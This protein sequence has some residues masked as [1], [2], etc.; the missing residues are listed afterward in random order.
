[1]DPVHQEDEFVQLIE[2]LQ[3]I[4][5]ITVQFRVA[6]QQFPEYICNRNE[7]PVPDAEHNPKDTLQLL[8]TGHVNEHG[9]RH[10]M[11]QFRD[12]EA[13]LRKLKWSLWP[14]DIQ[15]LG[16]GA[17][18]SV[19]LIFK[20]EDLYLPFPKRRMAALKTQQLSIF[21]AEKMWKEMIVMKCV[22]HRNIVDY[23][24]AFAVTPKT[25]KVYQDEKKQGLHEDSSEDEGPVA[26]GLTLGPVTDEASLT[27]LQRKKYGRRWRDKAAGKSDPPQKE[28]ILVDLTK[29]M[30][31]IL[32][33]YA[34]AGTLKT[35]I[36][37]Y[38]EGYL[39]EGA[40]LFYMLEIIAGLSYMH[41]KD[42]VH[43]DLHLGNILLKYNSDGRTKRCLVC[44][45]GTSALRASEQG[46]YP[47]TMDDI[48]RL[49]KVIMSQMVRGLIDKQ[50]LP[51]PA[52]L[53][54]AA[55]DVLNDTHAVT[56]DD[57]FRF[58]WFSGPAV[59]PVVGSPRDKLAGKLLNPDLKTR[60][61]RMKHTPA[62]PDRP[63]YLYNFSPVTHAWE[64]YRRPE[65]LS[66]LTEVQHE[67]ES[68]SRATA[69]KSRPAVAANTAVGERSRSGWPPDDPGAG[70]SGLQPPVSPTSGAR[71]RLSFSS[72]SDDSSN[73][74]RSRHPRVV[75]P[76]VVPSPTS[77]STAAQSSHHRQRPPGLIIPQTRSG[78]SASE[79]AS[80]T[81]PETPPATPA[82][83]AASQSSLTPTTSGRT[84][85][86][87]LP[88]SPVRPGRGTRP[89]PG[90]RFASAESK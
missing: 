59:A 29:D 57:L 85:A 28:K 12:R 55:N 67:D 10:P 39:G 21:N 9:E 33:E 14:H 40:A 78:R 63:R 13:G 4:E 88:E 35:E 80:H 38:P 53:S 3:R 74:V 89:S 50:P 60:K 72:S 24:G 6:V 27:G 36:K 23:Y 56:C 76:N 70:P 46:T 31:C 17:F 22:R 65:Y 82:A 52:F 73:A 1:M 44:D 75:A 71:R 64:G 30:F 11:P 79:P 66:Q 15:K 34:N 47:T 61:D 69:V 54:W 41:D 58:P 87:S 81:R 86:H 84:R 90:S 48:S 62:A 45:F 68:D 32:M 8:D 18:G 7:V 83:D 49:R 37:R 2:A 42:I 20:T 16:A 77:S 5:P 43:G 26:S 19:Q 51:I 25:G